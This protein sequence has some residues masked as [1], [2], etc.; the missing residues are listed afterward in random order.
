MYC[1]E[2]ALF[3]RN[4]VLAGSLW[5]VSQIIFA[6]ILFGLI[7]WISHRRIF[8]NFQNIVII[9]LGSLCG[10]LSEFCVM[11]GIEIANAYHLQ[12][13]LRA[14]PI[15]M[16]AYFSKKY[17]EPKLSKVRNLYYAEGILALF[18]LLVI[19]IACRKKIEVG[20]YAPAYSVYGLG[21]A[22][23]ILMLYL[24]QFICK[25]K[26]LESIFS[27]LGRY[28]FE[29]MA[30]H[31]LFYYTFNFAIAKIPGVKE[32]AFSGNYYQQFWFIQIPTICFLCIVIGK[33]YEKITSKI[34]E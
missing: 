22:G 30:F 2:N 5:F 16:I 23:I 3:I 24:C 14:I 6:S 28:S 20:L 19:L 21:F 32:N 4:D 10:V 12:I 11:Y 25:S 9:I 29:L 33:L 17:I 13:V 27:L 18:C 7:I 26:Y 34:F 15:Y 1:I 31:M 8:S